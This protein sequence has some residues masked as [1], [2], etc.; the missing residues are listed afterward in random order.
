[1]DGIASCDFQGER[2]AFGRDLAYV[3]VGDFFQAVLVHFVAASS[4]VQPIVFQ[5]GVFYSPAAG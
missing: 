3:T 5:R 4:E 2:D 1:M